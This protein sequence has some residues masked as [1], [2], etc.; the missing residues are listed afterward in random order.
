MRDPYLYPD[1]DVVI[2]KDGIK[3]TNK[4]QPSLLKNKKKK[5]KLLHF[6]SVKV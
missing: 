3:D 5:L 6:I 1:V 4:Q 2:N